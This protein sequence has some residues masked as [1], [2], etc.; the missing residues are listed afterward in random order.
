LVPNG[1]RCVILGG[2]GEINGQLD[3][4]I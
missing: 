3:A 1:C 4:A 2:N